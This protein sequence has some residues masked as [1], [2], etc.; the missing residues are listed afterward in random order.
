[1]I[2]CPACESVR[3]VIVVSPDPHGL[4]ARC[5]AT[6]LQDGPEQRDVRSRSEP[7]AAPPAAV[8]DSGPIP[9]ASA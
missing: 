9:W 3:V 5:G 8:N 2:R 6:W 4:C 7:V 1:M